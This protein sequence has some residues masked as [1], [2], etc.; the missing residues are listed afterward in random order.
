MSRRSVFWV[1]FASASAWAALLPRPWL[2]AETA[3]AAQPIRLATTTSTQNSGLLDELLPVFEKKSGLSI[4]VI[5]VGTGKALRMGAS[6]DVD[7]VMVHAPRAE[8][9]YVRKGVFVNRRPLM[10][11]YFVLLGPPADPA[12]AG[13]AGDITQALSRIAAAGAPFISRGDRS[14]THSKE[15]ELWSGAGIKPSWAAY[16]E[17][18]QGMGQTLI[19]A[20]EKQAYTLSDEGTFFAFKA[21]LKLV[22]HSKKEPPLRN[23]YSVM[24]VNPKKFPHVRHAEVMRLIEWLIGPEAQRRI[25]AYRRNGRRLFTPASPTGN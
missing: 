11:N 10:H 21:R 2:P 8:L 17:V 6:G 24:A 7:A 4:H 3:A 23:P 5:A 9:A 13:A 15:L 19:V 18:G 1:L 25:G 20:N 12:G 16:Q 14:G 22:I